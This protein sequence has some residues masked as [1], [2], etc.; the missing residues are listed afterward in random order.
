MREDYRREMSADTMEMRG[1]SR[2]RNGRMGVKTVQILCSSNNIWIKGECDF[3]CSD[4]VLRLYDVISSEGALEISNNP[5]FDCEK[6]K[7][8]A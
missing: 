8:K 5:D 1:F 4:A 2:V 6:R 7:R 3:G